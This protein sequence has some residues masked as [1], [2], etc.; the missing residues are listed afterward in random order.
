VIF[1]ES[2]TTIGPNIWNSK[3]VD[4]ETI[5]A[6]VFDMDGLM[7]N[8]EQLYIQV[9]EQLLQ[10]RGQELTQ[11]LLN[12]MMGRPSPIAFQIMIDECQLNDTSAELMAEGDELFSA[13]LDQ[14][15]ETMS[16]LYQLL[17]ALELANIPKAIATSSRREYTEKL[18]GRFD[19]MP[20]FQFA[21]T[22]EDVSQG[23]P[24]PE[25]YLS[26]CS[27]IG[28]TPANVLV[29][30]DSAN[31]CRAAINAGTFA[32]AVPGEH[33]R[34]HDFDGAKFIAESLADSRIYTALGITP[35][36]K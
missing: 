1:A 22:C 21:L 27:K 17:D 16:G 7:F 35:T 4:S 13:I 31:G 3:V 32:V 30:E 12:K 20:R 34:D 5:H 25:I 33:S 36:A 28:F 26:A 10:R 15:L 11:T 29:L 9:G 19:L 6:V 18:L 8:T 24:D 14:S 23:K 2:T